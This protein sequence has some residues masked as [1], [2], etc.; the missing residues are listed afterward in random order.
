MSQ[1]RRFLDWT[2]FTDNKDGFGL[3]KQTVRN[4]MDF[5]YYA[6]KRKFTAVALETA[7][8]LTPV[9]ADGYGVYADASGGDKIAAF[10][11]KARI[12]DENSPHTFL[13]DPCF[14]M[15]AGH[16]ASALAS[17]KQHTTFV[18]YNDPQ[19][20]LTYVV[21]TGDLV[22]VELEKGSFSYNLQQG[23]FIRIVQR[24]PTKTFGGASCQKLADHFG[25]LPLTPP[26]SS[27]GSYNAGNAVSMDDVAGVTTNSGVQIF[28]GQK[29]F[30]NHLKQKVSA[31]IHVTSGYRNPSRQASAMLNI[32]TGT[33]AA[34]LRRIYNKVY[35]AEIMAAGQDVGA[36]AAVIEGQVSRQQFISAH[37]YK[38]ALD[39]RSSG[40]S[41]AEVQEIVSTARS[42]GASVGLEPGSCWNMATSTRSGGGCGNQHIHM[43]VP[44]AYMNGEH[45]PVAPDVV[46]DVSTEDTTEDE[47]THGDEGVHWKWKGNSSREQQAY[48][49]ANE[50]EWIPPAPPVTT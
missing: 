2:N 25:V 5:D 3:V 41:D 9:E 10:I 38:S 27:G 15:D 45:T 16:K 17:I 46:A 4:A 31:P 32:W 11:F 49:L 21:N 47:V 37:L 28:Q 40:L 23:R 34:E 14:L 20:S 36:M 22:E 6:G 30:L 7:Y 29:D 1:S 13:P 8:N 50:W 35:L 33:G 19:A 43:K 24:G 12:V 39:L 44:D 18:S 42:L 48:K 26:R